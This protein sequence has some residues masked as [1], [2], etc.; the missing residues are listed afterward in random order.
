M[1]KKILLIDD[2]SLVL[3]SLELLLQKEG[4][5]VLSAGSYEEALI[6]I[7]KQEFDLVLS[8]IRMPGKDGVATAKAIQEKLTKSGKKDLPIVFIT[9]YAGEEFKLEAPFLGETLYKP[10][11]TEKLL[12]TL[13]EY[14]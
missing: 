4:Y 5:V 10:I 8:D 11:D 7:E 12:V 6:A 9:G 1:T 2:D 14:L 13:R 3:R